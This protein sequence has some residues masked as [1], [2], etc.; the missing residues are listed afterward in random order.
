M[1]SL[2]VWKGGNGKF[3]SEVKR[4]QTG[5][6]SKHLKDFILLL[7]P[8]WAIARPC[9]SYLGLWFHK[10]GHLNIGSSASLLLFGN[11][12]IS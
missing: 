10:L 3:N 12:A 8:C 11:D 7:D 6:A 1:V 9:M 2:S 4:V 5:L